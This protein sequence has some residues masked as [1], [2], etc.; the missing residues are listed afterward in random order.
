MAFFGLIKSKKVTPNE[1]IILTTSLSF[2]LSAGMTARAGVDLITK[3]P[4]KSINPA[5]MNLMRD[6]FDEG[7]T[8]AEIFKEHED[9]F[10]E[11]L[12]EQIDVAQRT[13]KVP[14]ALLKISEQIKASKNILSKVRSAM[15]Y[16]ILVLIIAAIAGWYLMTH[17]I[18]EMGEM[19][20]DLGAELPAMTL[21]MMDVC[22]FVVENGVLILIVI[23]IAA[24]VFRWLIRHPLQMKWHKFVSRAPLFGKIVVNM[25]YA[26]AYMMINDMVSNGSSLVDSVKIA[27]S[28]ISNIFIS[29]EVLAAARAME[30]EGYTLSQALM[31]TKSMPPD[32]KLM[33]GVGQQ[34]GREMEIL[35]DLSVRRNQAANQSVETLLELMSPIIMIFVCGIV[36][37]VVVSIYLPMLTM[38]S[39][40]A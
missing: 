33:L 26:R 30:R 25:S 32:D 15:A 40:M 34:T 20:A 27:S 17:T 2:M 13:G 18:P 23:V 37:I 31:E 39:S 28:T 19:M 29:S 36:G 22:N 10:G 1:M 21:F 35:T 38:A 4:S 9:I 8:L 24:F 3:D 12:W 5:A 16:P 7:L 6:S 11:G 14:E